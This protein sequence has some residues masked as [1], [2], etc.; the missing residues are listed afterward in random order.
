LA[1]REPLN[2]NGLAA[3]VGMHPSTTPR[4]IAPLMRCGWV[5]T[6]PG[7][8]RRERVIVITGKGLARLVRAYPLWADIQRKVVGHLGIRR[9]SSTTAALRSLRKSLTR[10]QDGPLA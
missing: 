1:R 5:R 6:Q 9:W 7:I 4:L 8:D 3:A 10:A 2:V